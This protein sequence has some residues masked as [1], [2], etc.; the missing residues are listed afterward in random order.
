M[1]QRGFGALDGTVGPHVSLRGTVLT[2]STR[3]QLQNPMIKCV[4]DDRM[5]FSNIDLKV[6]LEWY[7]FKSN[8]ILE[9]CIILIYLHIST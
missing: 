4:E 7:H 5:H 6:V 8:I 1:S 2:V 3:P 9:V